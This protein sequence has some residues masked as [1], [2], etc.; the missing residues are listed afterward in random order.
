VPKSSKQSLF[1]LLLRY[2]REATT[3]NVHAI[4]NHRLEP[5]QWGIQ[6]SGHSSKPEDDERTTL[7]HQ[8]SV[9]SVNRF[10]E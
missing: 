2:D 1:G 8:V 5:P 9:I 4:T 7:D 10:R 6:Q 3:S